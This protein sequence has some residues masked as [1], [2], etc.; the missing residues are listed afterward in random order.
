MKKKF[1]I[2]LSVVAC[3]ILLVVGSIAGT[4][5]YLTSQDT[6]TNTFTVG[7]VKITMDEAK[8]GNDGKALTGEDAARVKENS[9][10]LLPGHVYDKDPTI[11][12]DASSENCWLFVEITDEIAAI[13]DATT[14]A[15]QLTAKG[16]VAVAGET[17]VYAYNQVATAGNDY[18]VFETVKVKGTVTNDELATYI[19]KKV[20]VIAYAVQQDG[21]DTAAAAWAAAKTE[22]K[23]NP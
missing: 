1:L 21:F 15:D 6:V 4:V 5:A 22:L 2:T 8:V 18:V 17:N 16:W 19:N 20:T 7:N 12:V 3:A 10:K 23:P 13:Q 14:I 11:H 9:Y